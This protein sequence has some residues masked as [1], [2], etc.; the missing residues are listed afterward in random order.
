MGF[1]DRVRNLDLDPG[2]V[3]LRKNP[4]ALERRMRAGPG[5][6]TRTVQKIVIAVAFASA[7]AM[8]VLSVL[9]HR[10]GWS[11]VP[12]MVS[13]VGDALV[14]IGLGVAM[15]AVIQNS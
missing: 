3:S 8:I 11:Q 4:A 6:E 10:F 15:L 7:V 14:V 9:D 13:V 1:P 5:A 2:S 12:P